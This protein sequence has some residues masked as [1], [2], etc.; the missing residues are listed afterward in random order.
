VKEFK[1][2]LAL[3]LQQAQSNAALKKTKTDSEIRKLST[4]ELLQQQ[5]KHDD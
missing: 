3:A 1:E 4:T 5:D 2:E